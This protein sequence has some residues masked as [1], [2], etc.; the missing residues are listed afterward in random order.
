MGPSRHG[1]VM[2]RPWWGCEF[3]GILMKRLSAFMRMWANDSFL[4]AAPKISWFVKFLLEKEEFSNRKFS[5]KRKESLETMEFFRVVISKQSAKNFMVCK[6]FTQE[7]RIFKLKIW[8][9][10]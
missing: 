5:Q 6:A 7:R 8:P 9:K 4:N 2:Q 1:G 3:I 10:A